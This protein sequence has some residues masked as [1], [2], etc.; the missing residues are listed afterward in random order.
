MASSQPPEFAAYQN[1]LVPPEYMGEQY[2][3]P[4]HQPP[5]AEFRHNLAHPRI[6]TNGRLTVEAYTFNQQSND[7]D[8]PPLVVFPRPDLAIASPS[9][10]RIMGALAA[11]MMSRS[12]IAMDMPRVGHASGP[13]LFDCLDAN[14]DKLARRSNHI[15]DLMGVDE[16]HI[17]SICIGS[18]V[19]SRLAVHR[20]SR[21]RSLITYVS[22]GFGR[23]LLSNIFE[24][25]NNKTQAAQTSNKDDRTHRRQAEVDDNLS[26]LGESKTALS[27]AR[28]IRGNL[29]VAGTGA[30]L[31][32][33]APM[34][35]LIDE[36]NPATQW[37]DYAGE[38]DVISDWRHHYEVL[39]ARNQ[40]HPGSSRL[41][42]VE[43]AGHNWS[44]IRIPYTAR[45]VSLALQEIDHSRDSTA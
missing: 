42:V 22:P 16:A 39:G 1:S 20:G 40:R 13:G 37:L 31:V 32:A 10:T 17:L 5:S 25:V 38:R 30:R 3:P 24:Q 6:F 43:G 29:Y 41:R 23:T 45:T 35:Q 27:R 36:L 44:A 26:V 19:A 14:P 11:Q 12:V 15:L 4:R 21:A 7:E 34:R 28:F 18:A 2:T 8:A 33:R 9:G